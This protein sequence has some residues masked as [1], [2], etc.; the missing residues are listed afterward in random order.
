MNWRWAVSAAIGIYLC[1][2]ALLIAQKPGLQYD[3]ALLVVNAVQLQHSATE[4]D[5]PH[6]PHTWACAFDHCLPLMSAR[7]VGA[8][9]DYLCLPVFALFGP[10]TPLIRL[11]SLLLSALGIWGIAELLAAQAGRPAAIAAAFILAL[12][13]GYLNMSAFDN[14]AIGTMMAALGLVCAALAGYLDRPTVRRAFLLGAAMGFGIWARANFLWLLVA[15]GLSAL[16]VFRRTLAAPAAHWRAIALGGIAG[17]FPFLLYQALSKGGTLRALRTSAAAATLGQLL[18]YRF[19]LLRD[20]FLSDGEHRKMWGGPVYLPA[21]QMWGFPILIAAAC[22]VCL[23]FGGKDFRRAPA[24]R[25]TAVTFLLLTAYLLVSRLEVAEH[26]LIVLTP[27]AAALVVL[28]CSALHAKYSWARI[29]SLALAAVYAGSAVYW[30]VAAIRGLRQTGGIGMWSDAVVPLAGL[31]DRDFSNREV[32]VLDWGLEDNLYILTKEKFKSSNLTNHTGPWANE[33]RQGGLFLLN[34]PESR[35]PPAASPE[36]LKALETLRPAARWHSIPERNGAIYAQ[37]VEIEPGSIRGASPVNELASSVSMGDPRFE[38]QLTGFY[39]P[40]SD[41]SR[42][43]GREFSVTLGSPT[44]PGNGAQF[45]M[46]LYISDVSI[47]KL[48]PLTLSASIGGHELAPAIY[49]R[50]GLYTYRRDLMPEWIGQGPIHIYCT[51]D[52][53]LPPSPSDSRELGIVVL[54]ASAVPE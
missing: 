7:Y 9:K 51:L 13:P 21:W 1:W 26:H 3:E 17:G 42:W 27:I 34:G 2:G 33:I 15:G 40:D 52:K 43:T 19:F 49:D 12:N 41:G 31:I 46:R 36:F 23:L 53:A 22:L 37:L 35:N 16:I 38:G 25:F 54:D 29:F 44:S 10:R 24:A 50:S 39:K 18:S 8:V 11:V 48:G 47:Q 28:A 20:L 32:K 14:N 45:S 5:L 6:A 4:I 30:N